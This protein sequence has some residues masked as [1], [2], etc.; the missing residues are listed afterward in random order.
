MAMVRLKAGLDSSF[1]LIVKRLHEGESVAHE[2]L[3][4]RWIELIHHLNERERK[5]AERCRAEQRSRERGN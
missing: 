1:D 4:R 5:D 3:P 2:V